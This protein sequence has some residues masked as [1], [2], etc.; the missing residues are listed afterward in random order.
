[1]SSVWILGRKVSVALLGQLSEG[2][3]GTL[4]CF[5]CLEADAVFCRTLCACVHVFNVCVYVSALMA[6]GFSF[7][8]STLN[9]Y[10]LQLA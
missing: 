3:S 4:T 7:I 1:M 8:H 5:T 9:M 10:V 6:C 2:F